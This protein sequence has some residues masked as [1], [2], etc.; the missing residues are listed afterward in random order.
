MTFLQSPRDFP[1]TVDAPHSSGAFPSFG[2][3]RWEGS[4]GP[5]IPSLRFV[6]DGEERYALR[7]DRRQ[8]LSKGRRQSHRLTVLGQDRF[9]YDC[10][11]NREP[12]SNKVTLHLE[13]AGEYDFL[14]QPDFLKDP[15]LAG[16][17]AVYRKQTAVGQGTG[18]LC[19]IHRP[20]IIDGRGRRVWGDLSIVGDKLIITIPE[21]WLA[22]A[23]YPVVVDPVVGTTTV[24]SQTTWEQDP[25]EPWVPVTNEVQ[26]SV[27]RFILPDALDGWCTAYYHAYSN[28]EWES[29]GYPVLYSDNNNTPLYRRSTQESFVD[30]QVSSGKPVGWRSASF[31]SNGLIPSGSYVWF[32]LAAFYFWYARF[33]YGSKLY[34]ID[35][36][37]ESIPEIFP[38][39]EWMQFFYYDFRLSMYFDYVSTQGFIRTL[40][41]GV[42]LYD[43]RER[44]VDFGRALIMN[45]RQ[46]DTNITTLVRLRN[47]VE[48]IRATDMIT[49]VRDYLRGLLINAGSV[50]TTHHKA[51]Y[52]RRNEDITHAAAVPLRHLIMF[53]KILTTGSVRDYLVHRFLKAQE[54]IVLKS[55][56]CREIVLESRIH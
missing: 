56:V 47:L 9:E 39:Q 52:H 38:G 14:R 10:I 12:N 5:S 15:L 53:I 36:G 8:L 32:G 42:R 24:G 19:H 1:L 17:Y 18:K 27:N 6:P 3:T 30:L 31:H 34:S 41:Q 23:T 26:M 40:T 46:N 28:A 35:W 21:A 25:G 45:V 49:L 50:A 54:E 29:G 11:L 51:G 7:G 43:A 44:I 55:H 22:D 13:G 4:R 48:T 37:L 2:L 16:S 33:D 20:E